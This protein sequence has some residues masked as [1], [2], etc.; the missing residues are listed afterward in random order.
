MSEQ[1]SRV[2]CVVVCMRQGAHYL[3]RSKVQGPR[4]ILFEYHISQM[5]FGIFLWTGIISGDIP[6]CFEATANH[7]YGF[8]PDTCIHLDKNSSAG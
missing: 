6:V 1:G 5:A 3:P 2:S 7:G 8:A 4:L